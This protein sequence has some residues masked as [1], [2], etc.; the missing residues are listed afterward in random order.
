MSVACGVAAFA[1][2]EVAPWCRVRSKQLLLELGVA[3]PTALLVE[4]R[5]I[6]DFPG[7]T[8]YLGKRT[9]E[10]EFERIVLFETKQDELAQR[11]YARRG[12]VTTD[13]ATHEIIFRLF[14]AEVFTKSLVG[15]AATNAP[16]GPPTNAV[17]QSSTNAPRNGEWSMAFFDEAPPVRLNPANA[18]TKQEKPKLNE[19]TFQQLLAERRELRDLHLLSAK[20]RLL[21]RSVAFQ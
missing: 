14:D 9:G 2:L 12:H 13:P 15:N 18:Q 16:T 1:N 8:I 10:A 6:T 3:Q 4:Q 17:P 19:M 5:N 7:W 11:I 20:L 21:I